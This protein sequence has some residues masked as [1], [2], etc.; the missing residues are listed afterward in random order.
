MVLGN[1]KWVIFNFLPYEYKSLE[2]YLEKMALKGWI[3]ED[4]N[5]LIFKFRRSMPENL[6]YSVD[7]IDSVSFFDGKDSENLLE[8]R[9]YC[10]KAGWKFVC[11]RAKI[12]I[13]CSEVD[14]GRID[15]HTDEVEKFNTIRKAS[16][17][18][19]C[20][21]FFTMIFLLYSQYISTIG[22]PDG[23]FLAS[24]LNL[25]SLLFV[26]IFSIH[27]IIGLIT[28]LIFNIRGKFLIS[29]GEKI[30]YNFKCI[31]LIKKII[32]KVLFIVTFTAFIFYSIKYDLNI[33]KISIV[34][35][36]LLFLLNNIINFFKSKNYKNR[37]TVLSSI[38]TVSVL[39]IIF[40]MTN[41]IFTNKFIRD[42]KNDDEM[43]EKVAT[44]K[45]EDFDDI[46]KEDSLF[47]ILDKSPVAL[48]LF[49]SCEG[50]NDYLIYD[51]FESKYKWA[52]E[53]NFYKEIKLANKLDIEYIEK[54]TNLPNDIK[55]YMNERGHQ[56]I[57]I[58]SNK[59]VKI[60]T[61]EG[62]SEDELINVAYEKLFK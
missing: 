12:Q 53:Y 7:I 39:V 16:L 9:E 6:K 18:Y 49:Y 15:I 35:I 54:Q 28:F 24:S 8:Y 29:K 32:Y 19:V 38:Y 57:I 62:V 1:R 27:E 58:S 33:L 51:I 20:L 45:L 61:I 34:F 50:E 30:S 42:Y 4:M 47:Y 26:S 40:I 48:H 55:V 46:G 21:N 31:T 11:G 23:D 5:E 3:L 22:S 44:L 37:I 25:G 41:T 17:K 13:Y 59:M 52:V 43:L 56:Y 10:K 14:Q 36:L 2:E 60:S